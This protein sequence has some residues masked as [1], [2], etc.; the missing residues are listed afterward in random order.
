M[1]TMTV[2]GAAV[3]TGTRSASNGT[4][5]HASPNPNDERI[6]VAKNRMP[7]TKIDAAAGNM[8]SSVARIIEFRSKMVCTG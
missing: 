5:T 2:S 1:D 4:A 8:F 3:L 6:R 7:G